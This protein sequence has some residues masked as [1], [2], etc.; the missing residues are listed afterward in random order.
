MTCY[1]LP[2]YCLRPL[3][4]RPAAACRPLS[5]QVRDLASKPGQASVNAWLRA[6]RESQARSLPLNSV[7]VS[8][9]LE[10]AGEGNC[11]RG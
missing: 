11:A 5:R 10:E 7:L 6:V 2:P 4:A 1:C 3:H 8:R 9:I